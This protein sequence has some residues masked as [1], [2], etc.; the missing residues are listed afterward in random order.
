MAST[1]T[2]GNG[3]VSFGYAATRSGTD[4][5]TIQSAGAQTQISINITSVDFAFSAP[6]ANTEV[7]VNT[8]RTVSVRYASGGAGVAGKVISFS[9]TR[10]TVSPSQATTDANGIASTQASAASVG[11]ATISAVVDNGAVT[12]LP[13]NFIASTPATLVLQTSSAALPPNVAGSS[14]NQVQLRATV[15]DAA[16]NA[17]KGKTVFFT[18]VQDLSGGSIKTGSAVTDAN[19]LATDVFISGATST[20]ANG[21]Q[22]RATVANTNVTATSSLTISSQALFITIAANNTIEKLNTTYRKTFSVQ[23]NDANGAPVANQNL[24]LS[25]WPPFYLKGSPLVF[26]DAASAWGYD[27]TPNGFLL[28]C[29]NEDANRNGILDAGEDANGNGQ[30]TPGLPG[31]IAPA[32]VTTDAAGSAEFTLTYGQQY[33]YWVNFELAAKAI[34]SGTESSSFFAFVA[35]AAASDLTDKTIPP[36]SRVSPFGTASTCSTPN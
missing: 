15:R 36:A 5:V 25:Y 27:T 13:L 24:T 35:T 29:V 23:V 18:A 7:E 8:A 11:V 33:A 34:V 2:D 32:S 14:A 31:V 1:S 22:I 30:L 16:G 6:T 9:T 20:A 26:S 17:V 21:V 4:T 3:A 10:G 12:T 28:S 19:G